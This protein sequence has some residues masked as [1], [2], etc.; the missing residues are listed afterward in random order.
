[1]KLESVSFNMVDKDLKLVPD[2]PP[3]SI[4]ISGRAQ[5]SISPE[6]RK[7]TSHS[8]R[9]QNEDV[10]KDID[11][12]QL[13]AKYIQLCRKE[14]VL[15]LP[16]AQKIVNK[17]LNLQGY[18]MNNGQCKGLAL[19]ISVLK[20]EIEQL[21]MTQ[22]GITDVG[23]ESIVRGIIKNPAI[24][25]FTCIDNQMGDLSVAAF[26]DLFNKD[27][28]QNLSLTEL[29][30]GGTQLKQSQV[31]KV[32][33]SLSHYTKFESFMFKKTVLDKQSVNL[34]SDLVNANPKLHEIDISNCK[35][36]ARDLVEFILDIEYS[37]SIQRLNLSY[38]S[39]QSS[40][41]EV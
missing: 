6:R 10:Q 17:T 22:N 18:G 33:E 26:Q 12:D 20:E 23:I 36:A 15:A 16:L 34:L 27:N 29:H 39:L 7:H 5:Y 28:R 14:K 9:K 31:N 11:K 3:S 2:S 8:P 21:F 24:T 30:I 19:H 13:Q 35:V 40:S 41:L 37:K 4:N 1:M 32:L 38:N 25:R